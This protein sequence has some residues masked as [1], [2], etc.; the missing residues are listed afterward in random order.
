MTAQDLLDGLPIGT[1]VDGGA[2][3]ENWQAWLRTQLGRGAAL[4]REVIHSRGGE[5]PLS[6]AA[7]R[8]VPMREVDGGWTIELTLT[9]GVTVR[10]RVV[11]KDGVGVDS[12]AAEARMRE[13]LDAMDGL[14][15]VANQTAPAANP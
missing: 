15:P 2:V 10:G 6:G 11:F 1:A 8:D 13:L 14:A 3:P 5:R 7:W 4:R 9:E 12:L